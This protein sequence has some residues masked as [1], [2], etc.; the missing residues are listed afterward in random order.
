MS[1]QLSTILRTFSTSPSSEWSRLSEVAR[2]ADRAGVDRLAVSDHVVFGE[3]LEAYGEP[4]TGGLR[5]GQQPT[6]P[7]GAWLEPLTVIAHLTAVT[8]R[9][10]FSTNILL[11]ALRRPAVLAKTAATIDVLS[12]GRLDLGVGVGWQRAEYEA[13]GLDFAGRGRLLDH[14]LEVCQTLWGNERAA[15]ASAELSF[16]DIHQMPKPLAPGGVPLWISGSVNPRAMDRLARFGA[17]WLPWDEDAVDVLGGIA[18]MRSAM[19]QRGR[20]P[21]SVGVVATA[22]AHVEAAGAPDLQAAFAQLPQWRE[23]G[24]TDVRI[25]LT[26]PKGES[27]AE[28]YFSAVVDAFRASLT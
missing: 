28:E 2:A 26:P 15:Y 10:R 18:R 4:R 6:G 22:R 19:E 5:G 1:V 27:A 16:A 20:D 8:S 13:C 12:N 14:T 21:K 3:Q 7:D 9:V 17:G 23:A 25:S 11:A 24:V